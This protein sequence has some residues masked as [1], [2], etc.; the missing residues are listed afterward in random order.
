MRYDTL[1]LDLDGTLVDSYDA[2]AIAV[3]HARQHLGFP[4]LDSEKIKGFVGDGLETLLERV[5]APLPVPSHARELFEERYDAVC[6]AESRP[7]DG[8]IETLAT[9]HALGVRMAVCTNKP[10]SFSVKIV[11]HLGIDRYLDAVVGPDVAGAR[12]PDAR[13]VEAALAAAG[14]SRDAALF[15]GDMLVDVDAARNAGIACAVVATGATGIDVLRRSQAR[16]LLRRFADLVGVVT[17]TSRRRGPMPGTRLIFFD[18]DSTLAAIEGID[19]LAG[20]SVE[21]AA[22][23]TAAMNGEVALGEVYARRLELLRPSRG[24]VDELSRRYLDTMIPDAPET[25]E[26][27]RAAGMEIFI[28]SGG[29]EQAI[30]P[31]AEKLGIP[32]RCVHAVRLEFDVAGNY[33]GF[34]RSSPLTRNGGKETVVMNVR[35]RSKGKAVFIG[36]GI[37]DLEAKPAVELFIGFGGVARRERVCGEADVYLTE[38]RL[39]AILPH[40][41]LKK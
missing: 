3:N 15:V 37:T 28:V 14:G 25:M 22:L 33:A 19:E 30:L 17:G 16:H 34:D 18:A 32:Q 4:A 7:L 36:D 21:I 24:A 31:L 27:L 40:I 12:K 2:L 5:F 29:F 13:H 20:G 1:I 39:T 38:P 10:T 26:A 11:E 23:T 35:A 41:I 6:C 8:V 9:L